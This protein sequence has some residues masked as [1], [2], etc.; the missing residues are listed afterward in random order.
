MAGF[1]IGTGGICVTLLGVV[2]DHFGVPTAL[3]SIMALPV[4]GLGLALGL[5][6][7]Q[8]GG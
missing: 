2:A 5:R 3:Q 7:R 6:Y 8:D 1:A 4:I